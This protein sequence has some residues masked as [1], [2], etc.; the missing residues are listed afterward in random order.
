MKLKKNKVKEYRKKLSLTQEDLAD[1]VNVT[2]QTIL[3]VE[4]GRYVPSL[5]LALKLAK[6]FRCKVEDLFAFA[7]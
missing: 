3:F 4:K 5:E 6:L 1:V 7:L 2:R